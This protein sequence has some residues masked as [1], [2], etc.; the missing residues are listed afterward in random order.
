MTKTVAKISWRVFALAMMA[1]IFLGSCGDKTDKSNKSKVKKQLVEIKLLPLGNISESTMLQLKEDLQKGLESLEPSI[2]EHTHVPLVFDIEILPK[3]KLPDSCYYK[4]RARYRADKL[5]RFIKQKYG[6]GNGYVIGI[7][8]KDISTT[9]HNAEDYGIQGLSY[10]P[11]NV[12]IISTYRVKNQK[13]YWKLAAHEFCHGFFKLHHCPKKD[14]TCLLKD[15]EGGNPRFELKD[16]LCDTC[17]NSIPT[18]K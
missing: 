18:R 8:D 4:P 12:T 13:Y 2:K 16:K 1:F 17:L 9:I 10:C 3:D 11:G 14:P 6:K 7:T 15:A 5:L